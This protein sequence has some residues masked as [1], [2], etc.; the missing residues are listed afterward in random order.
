M[1]A[2]S[3]YRRHTMQTIQALKGKL[4]SIDGRDYGAYQSLK[5]E[6]SYPN[7]TLMITQIPKDP[8]APPHTGIYRVQV[9]NTYIGITQELYS[10]KT[11]ILTALLLLT[12]WDQRQKSYIESS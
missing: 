2:Y 7:F 3:G 9:P 12:V 6:Y 8:Y 10:T 1:P 5:G 11:T 4:K